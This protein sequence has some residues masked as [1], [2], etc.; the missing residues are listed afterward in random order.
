PTSS[1][2]PLV[3]TTAQSGHRGRKGFDRLTPGQ[4]SGE[5]RADGGSRVVAAAITTQ[6][7]SAFAVGQDHGAADKHLSTSVGTAAVFVV[8]DVD[9]VFDPFALQDISA[10]SQAAVRPLNDNLALLLNMLEYA[11]GDPLLIAIRSRGKLH[12]PFSHI[13]ELFNQA[14]QKYR[15]KE[16]SVAGRI[17]QVEA[18]LAKIPQAVG[19]PDFETLPDELKIKIADVRKGL[20]PLRRELRAVRLSM[21]ETIDQLG[22]RMTILNLVAGPVLVLLFAV[23]NAIWRKRWQRR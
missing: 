19:K 17:A 12:R 9:W 21:R 10:G 4:L 15:E 14:Q 8:S 6:L 1:A 23:F 11:G 5:F 3:T 18:E 22:R 2:V 13:A 16:V 7:S 20:L